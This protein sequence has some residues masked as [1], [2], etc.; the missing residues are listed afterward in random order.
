[1]TGD[2]MTR[3]MQHKS[4]E[5]YS[6]YLRVSCHTASPLEEFV[7]PMEAINRETQIKG[8]RRERKCDLIATM[9]PEWSDLSADWFTLVPLQLKREL[10][11]QR[12]RAAG[13]SLHPHYP[14]SSAARS[15]L[16]S[17]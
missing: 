15:A 13:A 12:R 2:L 11:G 9:N 8:W 3:V 5:S 16:T 6:F 4:G 10:H 7:S 1:M 17:E 14:D